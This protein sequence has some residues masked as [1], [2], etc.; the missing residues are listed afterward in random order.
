MLPLL[1]NITF[2]IR[3]SN[4]GYLNN[5]TE[6]LWMIVRSCNHFI[7]F[8]FPLKESLILYIPIKFWNNLGDISLLYNCASFLKFHTH[9]P[10]KHH[11]PTEQKQTTTHSIIHKY[12]T[13]TKLRHLLRSRSEWKLSNV[14]RKE[15]EILYLPLLLISLI[16]TRIIKTWW[17]DAPFTLQDFSRG[18]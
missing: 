17:R 11:P 9:H 4:I 2:V 13:S 8:E 16:N 10:E 15:D 1:L 12:S 5:E 18:E 6:I 7:K 14:W 3:E